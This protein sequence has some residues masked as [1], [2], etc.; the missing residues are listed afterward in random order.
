MAMA[1]DA[2]FIAHDAEFEEF[3]VK[4]ASVTSADIATDSLIE[5]LN[6]V[7]GSAMVS[8]YRQ[9]GSGKESLSF[10]DSFPPD[11]YAPDDILLH[12]KNTYGTG[13]YRIQ[14]RENGRLK[15]NKHVSIEAPTIVSR[16]T[17]SNN[18]GIEQLIKMVEAQNQ[19]LMR[20][21][22]SQQPQQN[23]KQEW[24]AEMLQYKQL[25]GGGESQQNTNGFSDIIK[26]VN[27]LKELGINVGGIQT[28]KEE[29]FTDVLDKMSPM[30]TALINSNA[31]QPQQPQPKPQPNPQQKAGVQVNFALKLGLKALLKAA[32]N[33]SPT[34]FYA[35]LVNEQF[36]SD[37]INLLFG[38]DAFEQLE[39]IEPKVSGHKEWF[40]DV[41]EH[42]KGLNGHSSKY[43]A[44]YLTPDSQDDTKEVNPEK[45]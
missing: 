5:A 38:A 22:Q 10:L 37:K 27:G 18:S 24:L 16:E 28:E 2:E 32:K 9:N 20:V 23:S 36:P 45:I 39:K 13:D 4:N 3:Q 44:E 26:T 7:S 8:L 35:D 15:A 31:Q 42:V 19:N 25:F 33:N 43:D 41:L 40:L 21:M 12:L 29:G 6:D 17:S 11:K 14:I 34:E 1:T 30:I